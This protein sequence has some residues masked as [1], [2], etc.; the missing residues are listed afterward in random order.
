MES[1]VANGFAIILLWLVYYAIFKYSKPLPLP[2]L[3]TLPI[4]AIVSILLETF[5]FIATVYWL[6]N[7][8][9]SFHPLSFFGYTVVSRL[10]IVSYIMPLLWLSSIGIVFIVAKKSWVRKNPK[11]GRLILPEKF[12]SQHIESVSIQSVDGI[13]NG[14]GACFSSTKGY[15]IAKGKHKIELECFEHNIFKKSFAHNTLYSKT[16]TIDVVPG[17]C[18]TIEPLLDKKSFSVS[19]SLESSK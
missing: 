3:K 15:L 16:I 19:R 1:I 13:V 5:A 9:Y 2:S 7:S 14:R 12:K 6:L 18:Y 8:N 17:V 4:W 10:S 11:Y